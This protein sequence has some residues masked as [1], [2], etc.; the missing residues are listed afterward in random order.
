[1]K[2]LIFTLA[3][4]VLVSVLSVPAFA[5]SGTS[6]SSNFEVDAALQFA[7]G[8]DDFDSGYG[9]N[10]G[11]GYLLSSIDKNLQARVDIGYLEFSK[12]FG[13]EYTRIPVVISGRYY[14]PLDER[15]K[16]FAQAGV[17]TSFDSRDELVPVP[18][19]GGLAKQTKNELRLGLVPGGGAEFLITPSIGLFAVGSLHL[20]SDGYFSIQFGSAIHF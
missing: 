8:P 2:K 16:L 9:I 14:F 4:L 11:A 1:M 12:D 19:F 6:S 3:A 10:L 18:I 20:I 5:A 13:L 15:L 7:T 17:E